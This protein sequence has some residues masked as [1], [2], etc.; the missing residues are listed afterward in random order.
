MK[1][2]M[3]GVCALL[4]LTGMDGGA[5]RRKVQPPVPPVIET[6][7]AQPL[8]AQAQRIRE[9]LDYLGEPLPPKTRAAL[10]AALRES[11]SEK[12]VRGVQAALDPLCLVFVTINP[13]ARV[14]V[15]QGQAKSALMEQGWRHFL[16]KV[17]NQ[18]GVTSELKVTSPNAGPVYNQSYNQPNP[19]IDARNR[20]LDLSAF[21]GQPLKKEL[22]G[23]PVEYRIIQLYSRDTGQR[24]AKLAFSAGPGTQDLGFRGE[25]DILFRAAPSAPLKF[26]VLDAD[27]KPTTAMFIVRD[28]QGRVYP[29]RAKRLAPDFFFHDQVYR[30][31]GETLKLPPGQYTLTYSRGPEYLPQT[32]TVTMQGKPQT[33]SV[34]LKRWVDPAKLGW[35][36]GDHHIHAAGCA[37]YTNPTEGVHAPDMMRHCLG[38]D[39]KIGAN[40]TWGP[41]FDYQKQFFT[42]KEDKV[43]QYPYLLRY[44]IEVSGFGSHESG[45]LCLLRLKEQ[46]YP[47]GTSKTHWPGSA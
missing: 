32:Q 1:G 39:L 5:A 18:A 40:L 25:V 13:E 8:A 12:L 28:R 47:G 38:E 22:S 7:E 23:L 26:R 35:W 10:E 36:S 41:C 33:V 30:A 42:G 21:T 45:H 2:I 6:V 31:D 24:E 29:S 43:S 27:G 37:H 19:K 34:R 4:L 17:H 20:W 3:F 15:A 44:D 16:V 11:D 14:K 9:A 46:M